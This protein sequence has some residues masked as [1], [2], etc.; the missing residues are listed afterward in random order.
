MLDELWKAATEHPF[1]LAVRDQTITAEAFDRWLVQD[2]HY[3]ADL[4]AFQARLLARAPRRAQRVLADGCVGLVAELDW[5]EQKAAQ[6]GVSLDAPRLPATRSYAELLARLDTLPHDAAVT[7]L[8]ALEQV[9][10]DAWTGARGPTPLAEFAE[11]WSAPEFR[12]YV[13]ALAELATPD[14]HAELV[15]E[16]LTQE[17]AFWD[18]ALPA[19]GAAPGAR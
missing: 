4:L 1:L 14:A 18:M 11:H 19:G 15:A 12:E 17:I 8:W 13:A 6:R 2:A 3:V 5:F 9:Y 16:V 10:L 7:A